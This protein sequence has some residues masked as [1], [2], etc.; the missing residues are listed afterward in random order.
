MSG[1]GC[2]VHQ[3]L[4]VLHEKKGTWAQSICSDDPEAENMSQGDSPRAEEQDDLAVIFVDAGS[5]FRVLIS[6]TGLSDFYTLH[7]GT[8]PKAD[9]TVNVKPVEGLEFHP[10]QVIFHVDDWHTHKKIR[11]TAAA[12]IGSNVISN[13]FV[14]SHTA[15]SQDPQYGEKYA[16]FKPSTI[17]ATVLDDIRPFGSYD[18]KFLED[19]MQ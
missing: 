17:L 4:T 19:A 16:T 6:Q 10:S 8:R 5:D 18:Q 14:I 7:L 11:V 13:E 12:V 15:S 1:Q 9:V 3:L 2:P